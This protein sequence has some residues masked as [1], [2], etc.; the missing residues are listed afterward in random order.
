MQRFKGYLT[1]VVWQSG[2]GYL[3]LWALT[4]WTLDSGVAVFNASGVCRPDQAKV[5]FYWTCDAASPFALL[6]SLANFALTVTVWA[7]VYVAAATVN[8]DAVALALPIV[9]FH[10]LGLPAA[11]Y[12]LIRLMVRFFDLAR[13]VIGRVRGAAFARR[14]ASEPP[15]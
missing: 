15:Q 11:I 13:L 7:P 6:A 10:V 1:A 12:V 3:A 5:L 2:L 14:L 4:F 9:L 8:V